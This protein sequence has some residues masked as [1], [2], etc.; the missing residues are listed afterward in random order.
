M[1][2]AV[3]VL[4]AVLLVAGCSQ[5]AERDD[6]GAVTAADDVSVEALRVGD[7]LETPADGV[8]TDL[9]AVPCAQPHDGEVFHAFD[10]P[11]SDF[12][13]E[14]AVQTAGEQG[15]LDRF[16]PFVGAAY[17]D[18]E[19][20]LLPLTPVAEG[21]EAGDQGVLCIVQD[22]EGGLTATLRGAAR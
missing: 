8:V 3:L 19:L 18:S 20:G 15:C 1:R 9:R 12:P 16:E 10:L 13:G 6:S 4:S 17:D 7:C 5:D 21:W 22:E 2:A 14:D 11:D